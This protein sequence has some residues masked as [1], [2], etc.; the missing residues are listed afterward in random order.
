VF[1][2]RRYTNLRLPYLI[3]PS[4]AALHQV[5]AGQMTW[6]KCLWPGR[7]PGRGRSRSCFQENH[8]S[9]VTKLIIF[10]IWWFSIR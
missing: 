7:G 3:L 1:T 2:T 6:W 10:I 8:F 9:H 5:T 4:V